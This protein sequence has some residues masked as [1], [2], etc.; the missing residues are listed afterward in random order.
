M[1]LLDD[2]V[3]RRP[4]PL[5]RLLLVVLFAAGGASANE[6]GRELD[7][8]LWLPFL[9]A[10]S[11]FDAEEFLALHSADFIRVSMDRQQIQGLTEYASQLRDGFARA[12]ARGVTRTTQMRFLRRFAEGDLAYESGYFRGVATL[13]GGEVRENFVLFDVVARREN[14][15]WRILLDKDTA[16][17][18]EITL[19]MFEAA[20]PPTQ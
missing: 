13:P 15:H 18:G 9:A 20:A 17:G 10:S 16:E 14:G 2:R 19:A 11:A 6:V 8:D 7:R 1:M 4:H 12:R 3:A 5:V